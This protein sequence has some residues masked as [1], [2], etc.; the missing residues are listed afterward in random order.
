MP[1][2]AKCT[3]SETLEI[4]AVL[5]GVKMAG[6][7]WIGGMEVEGGSNEEMV[8]EWSELQGR[9][10]TAGKGGWVIVDSEI[11]EGDEFGEGS[12]LIS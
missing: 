2:A 3:A 4:G 11:G 10:M 9:M 8:V 12:T 6:K 7:F 5:G 1:T